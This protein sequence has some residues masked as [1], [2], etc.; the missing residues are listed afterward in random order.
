MLWLAFNT[1]T[2]VPT[3][4]HPSPLMP[5]P[6]KHKN[7]LETTSFFFG[8]SDISG[9]SHVAHAH[10]VHRNGHQL[11]HNHVHFVAPS[12]PVKQPHIEQGDFNNTKYNFDMPGHTTN[13]STWVALQ[14]AHS[15]AQAEKKKR[16][17]GDGTFATLV[18]TAYLVS[19]PLFD[20]RIGA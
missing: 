9:L 8:D 6:Q 16:K 3:S 2:F 11:I 14:K 10:K 7:L 20:S 12:S 15:V 1:T 17:R 13:I 18:H 19:Q 5:Q 4:I